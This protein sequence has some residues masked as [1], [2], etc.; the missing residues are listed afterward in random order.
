VTRERACADTHVSQDAD[1]LVQ[2]ATTALDSACSNVWAASGARALTVDVVVTCRDELTR[3]NAAL[4]ARLDAIESALEQLKL[5][6]SACACVFACVIAATR[7]RAQGW[8][9]HSGARRCIR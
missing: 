7:V 9:S 1:A 2:E 6:A 3:D 5:T 4:A 8:L